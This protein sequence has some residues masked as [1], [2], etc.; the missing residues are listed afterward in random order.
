MNSAVEYGV[1]LIGANEIEYLMKLIAKPNTTIE[2]VLQYLR[3]RETVP[4][5]LLERPDN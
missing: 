1:G 2:T 5:L 3:P 4:D